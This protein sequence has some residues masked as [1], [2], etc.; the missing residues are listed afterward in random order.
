MCFVEVE[1]VCGVIDVFD[2]I[3]VSVSVGMFCLD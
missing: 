1:V 3:W 2:E